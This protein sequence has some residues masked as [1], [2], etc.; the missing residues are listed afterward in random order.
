MNAKP[1]VDHRFIA[2]FDG[3]R[4]WARLT[5]CN[6]RAECFVEGLPEAVTCQ[7]DYIRRTLWFLCICDEIPLNVDLDIHW[8]SGNVTVI[9]R[10]EI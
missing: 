8:P 3:R 1:L 6:G 9:P 7:K 2:E 4:A 5:Y 10:C